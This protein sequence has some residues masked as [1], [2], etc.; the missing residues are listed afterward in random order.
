MTLALKIIDLTD[1]ICIKTLMILNDIFTA[2]SNTYDFVMLPI[3]YSIITESTLRNTN[4]QINENHSNWRKKCS[5]LNSSSFLN[6]TLLFFITIAQNNKI[7]IK[8]T[9][10]AL[11]FHRLTTEFRMIIPNR[12]KHSAKKR[13]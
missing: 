3:N 1:S 7:F 4:F 11:C 6:R 5:K 12:I 10:F 13:N 9:K 2:P 8:I